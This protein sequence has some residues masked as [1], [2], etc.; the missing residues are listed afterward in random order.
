[1]KE[2]KSLNADLQIVVAFRMLPDLVWNMPP[3]GTVNL[4]GSLLPQY[5]GAAPINWAIINGEKETGVTTFKLQHEID[6]GNILLQETIPIGENETAGELHDR[7][8]EIGAQ[9]L[10]KTVEGLAN[11]T[12]QETPQ[13]S[14][15]NGPLSMENSQVET[16]SP[17]IVHHSLLK[18]APKIFTKNCRI[19]WSKTVDEIYNLIRGLS[20]YPAAFTELEDKTIKIYRSEKEYA[21]PTSK[22]GRWESN[23]KTYLKI[24]R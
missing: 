10:V 8:K 14:I 7:M 22:T 19:D 13:T 9:L 5:R 15:V 4:H 18:H 6:T 16:Y 17:L 12:L 23:G 3:M 2:L 1:L 11:G 21:I 20:P 24:C